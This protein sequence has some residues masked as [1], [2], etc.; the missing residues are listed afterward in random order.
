MKNIFFHQMIAKDFECAICLEIKTDSIL[1]HDDHL[2][3]SKCIYKHRNNATNF[4]C[5]LCKKKCTIKDI[6]NIPCFQKR[7]IKNLRVKCLAKSIG[8]ELLKQTETHPI[9]KQ[10][11]IEKENLTCTWSGTFADV[12]VHQT[13]CE[14]K[15]DICEYCKSRASKK[16]LV[17]HKLVCTYRPETCQKCQEKIP[18]ILLEDHM[19][20]ECKERI[21]SCPN[22]DCNSKFPKKDEQ[23]PRLFCIEEFTQ[24]KFSK[25]GCNLGRFKR[26]EEKL[27]NEH[28]NVKMKLNY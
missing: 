13:Q 3:C 8:K 26:K 21:V 12:E 9:K 1:L 5:P 25:F 23:T 2:F 14:Y 17:R 18:Y 11:I 6:K 16:Y 10:K 28:F 22:K 27:H 19:R 20:N 4:I 24:R 7:Q 15:E